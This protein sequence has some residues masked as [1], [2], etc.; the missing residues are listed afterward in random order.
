MGREL[1]ETFVA[2]KR[3]ELERHRAHVSEWELEEY[4]HH[5]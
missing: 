2:V 5:L 1:V 3:F 4:L